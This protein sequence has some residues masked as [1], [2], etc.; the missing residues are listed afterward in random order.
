MI[1]I[2]IIV[3]L[4]LF[5]TITCM[6]TIKHSLKY[7]ATNIIIFSIPAVLIN[8]NSAVAAND[9]NGVKYEKSISGLSYYNYPNKNNDNNEK[10]EIAKSNSKV[11]IDVKGYLAGRNGWEFID[12]VNADSSIR[13]DMQKTSVIEGLRLGLIGTDDIPPMHKG[14]KRR[15]IIFI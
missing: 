3:I 9:R 1:V 15:L 13:L 8:T 4:S 2:I 7:I 12:T 5:S 6:N 14:D 10:N 11:T